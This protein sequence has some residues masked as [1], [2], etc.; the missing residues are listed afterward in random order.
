[1]AERDDVKKVAELISGMKFAHLTTVDEVGHLISRPMAVQAVEF[2][3]DLWFYAEGS[4]R[5]V[6]NIANNPWVNVAMGSGSTY[7]SLAGQT[8]VVRD[9]AKQKELWNPMV[10]AWFP[11]GPESEDLVLLKVHADTAEYWNTPGGRIATAISFAKAK[12]TG[13]RYSGGENAVVE[14]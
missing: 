2:D 11:D 12:V 1:M 14:M 9:V 6:R 4:S 7:V 10:E 5:K 3:G 13:E 8:S